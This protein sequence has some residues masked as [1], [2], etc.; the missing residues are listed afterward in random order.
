MKTLRIYETFSSVQGESSHAGRPC[1]FI[2]LSGCNLRCSY[3]DTA[4]AWLPESGRET[5]LS[6]ILKEVEKSGLKLVEITGG[7]PMLQD[8]VPD[9]CRLLLENRYEVLMETNGSLP[10]GSLPAGV[11]RIIDWKTPSSGETEKMLEENFRNLRRGDEVK[12]VIAD[13][14][15]FE[16]AISVVK[17]F[18]IA[19]KAEILFAPVFGAMKPEKLVEMI[20]KEKIPARLNLQLHKLIWG[21]DAEGV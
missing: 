3:C 19:G 1:F 12:F 20:L 2:R 6:G 8:A 16:N 21:A 17:R 14:T 15:D 7:E 4:K 5:T 13:E 11:K 10:L 18:A 9:L